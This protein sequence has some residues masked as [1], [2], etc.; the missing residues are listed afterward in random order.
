[1]MEA[2]EE[3]HEGPDEAMPPLPEDYLERVYAGVLGK[4]I[5][6]YVGRPFEGWT[7]QRIIAQLGHIRYYVNEK[8]HVPIV[9]TDDDISGTF[10]FVR[11]LE[12]HYACNHNSFRLQENDYKMESIESPKALETFEPSRSSSTP[13]V[14]DTTPKDP[15]TSEQIG[16]TWLNNII[17]N[18]TVFWWGGNGVSTEHTAF[19]NLRRGIN[20]PYSGSIHT[21]GRTVAQQIGAQI[22]IDG[23]AM[24]APGNPALAARLAR[25][26]GSV[27]HD[28]EAVYAARLWAAMEAE[29]FVSKDVNHLLDTGLRFVPS[30]SLI[31]ALVKDV[32]VWCKDDEDW[33]YTRRRIEKKYGYDKF[34]GLCHVVPNHGIMI[35]S[36]IYGGQDFSE[37]MHI[38]NT[39]GWDTDCNSGNIGCLVAIMHGLAAFDP[40]T[41]SEGKSYDWRGPLTDRAL[42][43]SADG[44]YSVNNASNIAYDIA[45][46]GRKLA[47][48]EALAP[49]KQG[50][51]FHFSLPGSIQG[52]YIHGHS[53]NGP[54][55]EISHFASEGKGLR[56]DFSARLAPKTIVLTDTFTP[57]DKRQT[58]IYE[59]VAAPLVYPGQVLTVSL[60]AHPDRPCTLAA[61]LTI[62][63]YTHT[64]RLKGTAGEYIDFSQRDHQ[65][66]KWRIPAKVGCQPIQSVGIIIK[67]DRAARDSPGV[68]YMDYL[69]WDGTPALVLKP[70]DDQDGPRTFYKRTFVNGADVFDISSGIFTV[71]QDQG[72]GIVS[73]GTRDWTNYRAAFKDFTVNMG[74]PAGVAVRVRGLKR[75]YALVFLKARSHTTSGSE[76]N[77]LA[78]VKAL[79][80]E[81]S[82]LA[83]VEFDWE[84]DVP[85]TVTLE[86]S[87]DLLHARVGKTELE[88]RDAQFAGGGVGMVV[89]DGSILTK[90]IKI[91][92]LVS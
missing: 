65:V 82:E 7:H 54:K 67:H 30:D 43:S 12:E 41:D 8:L 77:R 66:L 51:Q 9:V 31:A 49:P 28:G 78:L 11:A 42:I 56:I 74:G 16:K 39:S 44:G 63:H 64:D 62:S 48:E 60:R 21:N 27:S 89:T 87:D 68:M 24:T 1:M 55:G 29:A 70:G 84:Y 14:L 37:A 4:L 79:D 52:F 20:A 10:T 36:L 57:P 71:A 26:A 19:L 73:Y 92:P 17:K 69:R 90:S 72:E 83:S 47:G 22:F 25:A 32:R 46:M 59:L 61:R 2:K 50:A 6:V 38:V 58:S 23:F 5:G 86:A 53:G 45:N 76:K 18:R 13:G 80:D 35:M 15:I 88:A 75:Y 40:K 91:G 85:Y 81:R 33:M 3:K 34:P